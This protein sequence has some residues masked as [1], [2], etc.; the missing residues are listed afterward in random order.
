MFEQADWN[1]H[2]CY[3]NEDETHV[4]TKDGIRTPM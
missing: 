2:D 4:T 1:I 3:L